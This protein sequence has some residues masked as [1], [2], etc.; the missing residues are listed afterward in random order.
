MV[1]ARLPL[2]QQLRD[3]FLQRIAAGEW[4]L[5]AP[6]PGE[7]E[8]AGNLGVAIGTVRKALDALVAEG[9][10]IRRQGKG[11]FLRRANFDASLFRFFRHEERDGVRRVPASR[12]L[13]RTIGPASAELARQLRIEPGAPVIRLDRLRSIDGAVVLAEEIHLPLARFAA[14]AED[15]LESF[16]PLL[17]PL[18]ER[19]CGQI[20]TSAQETLTVTAAAAPQTG[21]LGV[22]PGTPLVTIERLALDC[23]QQPL[24]WRRSCGRG[25]RFRYRVEIR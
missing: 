19:R 2:Y 10:V 13:E 16:G 21:Q 5:D 20:V 4:T 8:L 9:V 11:T 1:D 22:P 7:A 25:E 12:I 17:Y 3:D 23:T 14:L 15:P 24:E 18:Y 6:L